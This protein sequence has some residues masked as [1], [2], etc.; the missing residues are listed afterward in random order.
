MPRDENISAD[1]S[2]RSTDIG[3]STSGGKAGDDPIDALRNTDPD[4]KT[5]ISGDEDSTGPEEGTPDDLK[6]GKRR[7]IGMDEDAGAGSGMQ[8]S[9]ASD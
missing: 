1:T 5:P 2:G 7:T 8:G 6:P 9:T 4:V 3:G